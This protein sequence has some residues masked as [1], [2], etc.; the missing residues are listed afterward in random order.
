[1]GG[2]SRYRMVTSAAPGRPARGAQPSAHTSAYVCYVVHMSVP[3][4][5][6]ELI[7]R[8]GLD[9]TPAD[10][11]AEFDAALERQ[12]TTAP[13]TDSEIV[14][15]ATN[16]G[17]GSAETI[18]NWEPAREHAERARVAL[19]NADALL[20]S[21]VS[22]NEAARI[23]GVDRSQVSR[24]LT[25]GVLYSYLAPAGRHRIPRWQF[26]GDRLIPGIETIAP[27]VPSSIA[28]LSVEAFMRTPQPEC[29]NRSPIE[30]LT[31]GGDPA[32]VTE[33]L[34]DLDRW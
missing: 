30:Y 28:P 13:L 3:V 6:D 9:L 17:P 34:A 24:R 14:F 20:A 7:D 11:L 12:T 32:V 21:T 22:P 23:L 16:A 27:A 4:T 18:A 19:R 29:G 2:P 5:L 31:A 33:L 15:L 25:S 26:T 1:M 8:Y 10:V